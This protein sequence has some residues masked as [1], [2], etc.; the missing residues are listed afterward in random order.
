MADYFEVKGGK[1]VSGIVFPQGNK[2]EALPLLCAALLNTNTVTLHNV[3]NICDIADLISILK[4]L[5]SSIEKI[6]TNSYKISTTEVLYTVLPPELTEK[7]R[8]S[9]TLLAPLLVREQSVFLPKPGGD[10]IGR[11]RVDT[12]L[13]GL[14]ALGAKVEVFSHGYKLTVKEFIGT[15]IL[16]DEASV[17]ATA[18]II[19]AAS[20]AKGTT[21][22]ENAACEPHIQGLCN[23]L[24]T[25]GVSIKGV[26]SNK[27]TIDGIESFTKL[28]SIDFTISPDYIEI[29]S[30][31]S[32]AAVT[33]GTLRIKNVIPQDLRMIQ[34]CFLKIGVHFIFEKTKTGTDIL[35]NENQELEMA[36]DIHGQITKVEDAPWPGFPAD[37]IS[38]AI[39]LASQS[40]G[41]ILFH[42][43]MF[44]S[45]L[46]FTDKLVSMGARIVLCDPHRAIVI[47]SSKLYPTQ[48]SSPDIRAG[49]AL[50]I[51]TAA[52]EGTSVI[53]NVIQIDRGYQDIISRLNNIG[54]DIVRKR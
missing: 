10:K 44:E 15:N 9:I 41:T 5:G 39:T 29:G 26:G 47:G 3:P 50:L 40:T 18:N 34:Y 52:A 51:A 42:E 33:K 31:I 43:K 25:Q 11:R 46:Y 8:G 13:L 23:F 24:I 27:L 2:N 1:P 28:T 37:L 48:L 12:H 32:L 49:M 21:V 54:I 38:I 14:E 19:M 35:I 6:D 53:Q 16:L 30:F 20:V 4:Y 22:I 17:T 45:R 7:I 36:T